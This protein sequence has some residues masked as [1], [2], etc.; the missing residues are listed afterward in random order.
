MVP[1]ADADSTCQIWKLFT[2]FIPVKE[3]DADPEFDIVLGAPKN[4]LVSDL[5]SEKKPGQFRIRVNLPRLGVQCYERSGF[6][7]YTWS[8]RIAT[9]VCSRDTKRVAIENG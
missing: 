5:Q 1:T 6:F 9:L 2:W 3:L 8:P 7:N 4:I